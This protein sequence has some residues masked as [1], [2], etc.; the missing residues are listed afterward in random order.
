[1][2]SVVGAAPAATTAVGRTDKNKKSRDSETAQ[3]RAGPSGTQQLDA[4]LA[5]VASRLTCVCV[6]AS[7]RRCPAAATLRL[8]KQTHFV[9]LSL[10]PS[11]CAFYFSHCG[12]SPSSPRRP[13][14]SVVALVLLASGSPFAQLL[15]VS[16]QDQECRSVRGEGG[17]GARGFG[18]LA[19]SLT[20]A[21]CRRQ[22][23]R[24]KANEKSIIRRDL[25]PAAIW[26][27]PAD[28]CIRQ[29][30]P[31]GSSRRQLGARPCRVPARSCPG[32]SGL[33]DR[34]LSIYIPQRRAPA[35]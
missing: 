30:A 34:L 25:S 16:S 21:Q 2:C 22:T 10:A 24:G 19:R 5:T 13:S 1:V 17:G 31:P 4:L 12:P 23:K 18:T 11:V 28:H 7:A 3:D 15:S 20:N 8:G 26:R 33:R 6:C 27:A 35:S 9:S 29:D 14:S 32:A